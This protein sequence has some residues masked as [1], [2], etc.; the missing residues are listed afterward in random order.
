MIRLIRY[1]P[2]L[3]VI[4]LTG[5]SQQ[6]K[7]NAF[8]PEPV[9]LSSNL[10]T[11][12]AL[13][14]FGRLSGVT[15]SPDGDQILFGITFYNLEEGRGYRDLYLMPAKGGDRQEVTRTPDNEH[16][17]S[18]RPDGLK[19]N[20]LSNKSGSTQLWE[21]NPDGS[22]ARQITNIEGGI[23]GYRYSPD[24]KR[25]AFTRPVKAKPGVAEKHPDL[26]HANARIY[27]DLMFRHW[28]EWVESFSHI[29]IA[30]IER[31]KLVNIQDI[32][33][34]E[35]WESPV[36][37]FGGMEQIVWSP[38]GTCLVYTARKKEGVEYA[39]ST[40]TDLFLYNIDNQSTINLTAGMPGYDKNPLFSPDGTLLAFESME[41]DGYESDKNRLMVLELATDS[42]KDLTRNFDQDVQSPIWTV[43]GQKLYFISD[44]Q[45][46]EDIYCYD[47]VTD[48]IKRVTEGIHNYTL[49]QPAGNHLIAVRQSMSKPDELYKVDPATG[50]AEEI[51]FIN[52]PLLDQIEMGRI[53]SRWINTT[54]GKQ[55]KVWVIYP[56]GFDP[57]RA[58]PTL[59]YCQGGPQ[60]TVSQFWSYRWN[61]QIMAANGYI[62]VAP[63]RRGVPGFGKEWKEQ[64]SGGYGGQNMQD[65]LSAIDS[66]AKEPYVDENRLG[67]VGA[68][69]GG[70]SVYWLAGHHEGRF[71]A[72]IAHD[73]AFNMESKYLETEEM[74]FVNWDLGGPFWD[75]LNQVAQNSFENSP[76]H[77]IQKWDTPILVIHG[78]KDYRIPASQGMQAFA[79]A[80][81]RGIPSRLLLF[82]E[83]NH[84]VLS[85]HNGILWQREFFSWLDQWLKD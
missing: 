23:T 84:W 43:D 42:I 66:L 34:G 56:P 21:I 31:G 46:T 79:A 5:C 14:S 33:E 27:D 51:S 54:D 9:R 85:A 25:I 37:P 24:I 72:F 13:W 32:M 61:F 77:F 41:R 74:W 3:L 83:E 18:W 73:G 30:E 70:F 40:N 12:E 82:P 53:E 69:Y 4:A 81:L 60:S 36:R 20:Y 59:L 17:E 78:E 7:T 45:A 19:I 47:G 76:H 39:L 44:Y 68:S 6:E 1:L 15:V 35:P 8:R 52:K 11:P 57:G 2:L 65:Y 58:Y 22:G 75:T 49:A 26:S 29:F 62:I 28:D 67:A 80:R 50:N 64:I 55:M 16:S 71:K 10:L 38:D 48:T 63:N